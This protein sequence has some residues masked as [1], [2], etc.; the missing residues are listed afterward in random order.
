MNKI[1]FFYILE[2]CCYK[3]NYYKKY[4]NSNFKA[5]TWKKS[6][7]HFFKLAQNDKGPIDQ[8]ITVLKVTLQQ[9]PY[10]FESGVIRVRDFS[11]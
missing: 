1:I 9:F 7:S 3:H 2:Q 8:I 5:V 6:C 10:F 4:L 11:G